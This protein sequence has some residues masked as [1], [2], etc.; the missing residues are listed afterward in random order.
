MPPLYGMWHVRYRVSSPLVNG[1][2]RKTDSQGRTGRTRT[3]QLFALP[4]LGNYRTQKQPSA[5]RCDETSPALALV[6]V[7]RGSGIPDAVSRNVPQYETEFALSFPTLGV[8]F[9]LIYPARW[10]RLDATDFTVWIRPSNMSSAPP[11]TDEVRILT[12]NAMLGYG[13]MTCKPRPISV[14]DVRRLHL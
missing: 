2:R 6:L 3:R 9:I 10:P 7:L 8:P 12:P 5:P 14:A 1:S 11:I 4:T 13:R